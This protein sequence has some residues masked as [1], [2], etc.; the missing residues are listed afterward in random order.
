M[1]DALEPLLAHLAD[2]EQQRVDATLACLT[3]RERRLIREAAVMGY[4][5]GQRRPTGDLTDAAILAQVVRACLEMPDLYPVISGV[6]RCA[7]C[8][9]P[10]YAHRD[11]GDDPVLPGTRVACDAVE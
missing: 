7:E 3:D 9:Q 1:A 8:G 11:G 4:A 2:R 5:Q 6:Q 10:K